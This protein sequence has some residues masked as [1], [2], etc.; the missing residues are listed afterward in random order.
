MAKILVEG[1]IVD[2]DCCKSKFSFELDEVCVGTK[3]VPAGYSPE[4]EAY[5]AYIFFVF[6][7]KCNHRVRVN[8]LIGESA[9][10]DM[11]ERA[12]SQRNLI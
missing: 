12:K 8:E 5:T 2:C 1:C 3:K 7:P 11:I 9:K 10:S 4:E 6:C